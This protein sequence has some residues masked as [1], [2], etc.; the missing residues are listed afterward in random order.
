MRAT[1][2][3]SWSIDWRINATSPVQLFTASLQNAAG[4]FMPSNATYSVA[5][6]PV[7]PV[8]SANWINVTF[9]TSSKSPASLSHDSMDPGL[10]NDVP[11][12]ESRQIDAT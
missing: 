10:A 8:T 12:S 5:S 11:C 7:P 6:L 4:N 2:V 1:L 9:T 3:C